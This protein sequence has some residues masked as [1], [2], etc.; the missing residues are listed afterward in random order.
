MTDYAAPCGCLAEVAAR[1]YHRVECPLSN[2][3]PRSEPDPTA[4]EAGEDMAGSVRVSDP[5][6]S[7]SGQAPIRASRPTTGGSKP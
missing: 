3:A 2:V 5:A 4:Q 1:G 7:A 6:G